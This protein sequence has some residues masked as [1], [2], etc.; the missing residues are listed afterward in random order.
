M[1]TAM[2]TTAAFLALV[3]G[4][5]DDDNIDRERRRR[6]RRRHRRR[7]R[8]GG[9]TARD[10][11]PDG[12]RRC[13]LRLSA[14]VLL[15]VCCYNY[16]CRRDGGNGSA[17]SVAVVVEGFQPGG[18]YSPGFLTTRMR[19]TYATT[20][21]T[22]GVDMAP[23]TS[24][25]GDAF[26]SDN[27]P[28]TT[29][30]T[31]TAASTTTTTTSAENDTVPNDYRYSASDWLQNIRSI[32]R[33]TIL[34]AIRFPVLSVVAWSTAVSVL[35]RALRAFAGPEAAARVSI[36]STPHSFLVSALGLLLVFRT[37]SAYQR[38]AEGRTI[39]ER[40]LS[41]S[42]NMSRMCILY[43]T[44]LTLPRL[45]RVF[46]LLA[47]FPYLLHHH[48]QPTTI[49]SNNGNSNGA[50]PETDD[51][52]R[53]AVLR[54]EAVVPIRRR[55]HHRAPRKVA[56]AKGENGGTV[57]SEVESTSTCWVD[58]RTVPWCLFPEP[59]QELCAQTTNRP[60]WVC[61]RLSHELNEVAYTPNFT[62]RERL[63]FLSHIDKLSQCVGECER[64]HQT[65]VPLNYARH[66]LRSLTLWLFTLP[67]ALV[68]GFGLLTGP[69]M[70]LAAWLLYGIYQIGY[71]IEDPFQ[72]SLR[73]NT[74]CDAV[75]RDVMYGTD[76]H[77]RR[78][79]AFVETDEE[80]AAWSRM[81][82]PPSSPTTLLTSGGPA[83]AEF[84]P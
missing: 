35:H 68:D 34:K 69:V 44:E 78:I 6:H 50:L 82:F 83:I 60:L 72:G 47:A 7:R 52:Y 58:R 71:Q 18:Y 63:T 29:T 56:A 21:K 51:A 74:L 2:T 17:G 75:F 22:R 46:R 77:N 64:I 40:I 38:F 76:S 80:R 19:T 3:V 73:L 84:G 4:P 5:V 79:T 81:D 37:N 12:K 10:A 16:C 48:I 26:D 20:T 62:S 33:S 8:R 55:L 28:Q 25:V 39:W 70:G 31:A 14:A 49:Q 1:M 43:E 13:K 30:A 24:R 45:R 66:S 61:D 32:P 36:G 67:F 41:V 57:S 42:R 9:G 53:L 65:A 11:A 23:H 15:A 54:S 59:V 27:A